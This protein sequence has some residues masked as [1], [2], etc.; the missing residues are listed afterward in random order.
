[1]SQKTPLP[2]PVPDPNQLFSVIEWLNY[3]GPVSSLQVQQELD[4][5]KQTIFNNNRGHA[6]SK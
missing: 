2:N 4:L 5:K 1:M 6:S 3:T